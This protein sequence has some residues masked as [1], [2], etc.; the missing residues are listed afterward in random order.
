MKCP[1]CSK[2]LKDIL[3]FKEE[4]DKA[5]GKKN[6]LEARVTKNTFFVCVGCRRL[7]KFTE[8]SREELKEK[9]GLIVRLKHLEKEIKDLRDQQSSEEEIEFAGKECGIPPEVYRAL[10]PL[11]RKAIHDAYIAR[12]LEKHKK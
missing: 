8:V 1:H 7:W 6:I 9:I 10:D 2:E 12:L 4:F 5:I 11:E 3:E